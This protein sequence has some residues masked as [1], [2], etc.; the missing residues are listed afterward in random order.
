MIAPLTPPDCDLSDFPRMMID[1]V[2][3][4]GSS[5]DA[6]LD[7][8]AWR[9]GFNLWFSSWHQVPAASLPN[10]EGTLCKFAGLGRDLK[11][12][13]KVRGEALRGWTLCDDGLLYHETVAEIALESWLEKLAQRVSSGAG[14]AKRYKHTFDPAPVYAKIETALALLVALNPQSKLIVRT[15]RRLSGKTPDGP[16]DDRDSDP[17]GLPVGDGN[18]PGGSPAG[19]QETGT[20]TGTGNLKKEAI[21]SFVGEGDFEALWR[22]YPHVKGRSSQPKARAIWDHLDSPTRALLPAAA[23]RYAVGGTIPQGGAPALAKW[24]DEQ[25][26]QDWL[27]DAPSLPKVAWLG[28]AALR[29]AI[30][31]HM[32][33]EWTASWLDPCDWDE[34]AAVLLAPRDLT[35]THLER[36]VRRQLVDAKVAEVR[37]R[38]RA[39]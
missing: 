18:S 5:F 25:R 27:A 23:K 13:K 4:R 16:A 6:V 28:P 30:V 32:G 31:K 9:A 11:S 37:V 38:G 39:A 35:V 36:S 17:D 3:L 8:G 15:R 20:G 22:A 33:E 24:L 7:D 2:R 14:N 19:S 29:A 12:W 34:E 21:A 1:I 26:W 10:D